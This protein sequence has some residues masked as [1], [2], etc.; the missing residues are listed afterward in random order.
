MLGTSDPW[1][2]VGASE[3]VMQAE[4]KRLKEELDSLK[5][6]ARTSIHLLYLYVYICTYVHTCVWVC[7]H[8]WTYVSVQIHIYMYIYIHIGTYVYD[9]CMCIGVYTH[10]HMQ[11][12]IC[13]SDLCVKNGP[14]VKS[15]RYGR[16]GVYHVCVI[17]GS[18]VLFA[19]FGSHTATVSA[20]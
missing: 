5:N 7:R 2:A 17:L 18:P 6:K 8:I 9:T 19:W 14:K 4:E 16:K 12:N 13:I 1:G 3:S 15:R 10:I 11:K 20:C